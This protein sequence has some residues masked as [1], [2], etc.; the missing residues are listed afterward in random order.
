MGQ[1]MPDI[2][3]SAGTVDTSELIDRLARQAE[4][5]AGAID[6]FSLRLVIVNQ[7]LRIVLANPAYCRQRGIECDEV[8]GAGI[9]SI[10]PQS[11]LEFAGLKAAIQSTFDTGDGVQW[12]GYRYAT[13]DHGERTLNIRLD[14]MDLA[15]GGRHVMLTIEDV[16]QRHRQLYELSVLQQVSQ[17]MLGLLELPRLLHA[18]LT[19]I[20]AGGAV[21][22][23]FNRAFLM[24]VDEETGMLGV[25]MAV[26]PTNVEEA[27]QIWKNVSDQYKSIDD[28]LADYDS[29][30][31]PQE[32]HFYQLV[33][34]LRLPAKSELLPG[35][36]LST[37]NTVNVVN[38]ATD[39]RVPREFRE[40]LGANEFVVAPL[41]ARGRGIGVVYADNLISKR[42]ISRA[43]VQLLTSLTN[44]AAM[45]I[46]SASAYEEV[47]K[48][49]AE[50][51]EA[52]AQLTAAQGRV[53]AAERLAAIGEMTAIIAHEIRNPLSTV[54]GFVNLM[55]RKP[56][57]PDR[58][59]RYAAI[60]YDEVTRL[61]N[62][63]GGLLA[64]SRPARLKFRWS[65][66]TDIIIDAV[67][68]LRQTLERDDIDISVECDPHL[69]PIY[70]DRDQ[71]RQVIDNL[72][73]N[74]IDAMPNGGRLSL[75]AFAT[76]ENEKHVLVTVGDTGVGIEPE[77]VEKIFKTFFTTKESG[78]GIGL[79]L[80]RKI[81]H[82]HGA[83]M[84]FQSEVGQG[85]TF[86]L[87]FPTEYDELRTAGIADEDPEGGSKGE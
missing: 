47:Q 53:V 38:A 7:D 50:L 77:N 27:S 61:E 6:R 72:M 81:V 28:F 69:P 39:D 21:G 1:D 36:A 42:P 55:L 30:E 78:M 59:K 22:L 26:G 80:C 5:T 60:V 10:F 13:T 33:A 41:V 15:R 35:F 29:M 57:D 51:G 83:T 11:L 14:A 52:N 3:G 2:V 68:Q 66:I 40:L 75:T 74:A 49:A 23:G 87:E 16:T 84:N 46:D 17:A 65:D 34:S 56:D 64:L 18:I 19:G 76:R 62:I 63:L 79:A 12:S 25:E 4:L 37:S 20:T 43:D 9:D 31:Q 71:M 82:D 24:L 85:T 45:A 70:I 67:E 58:I 73:H 54:G 8:V 86:R 32:S 48:R 44:H